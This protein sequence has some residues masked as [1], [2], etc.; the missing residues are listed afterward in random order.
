MTSEDEARQQGLPYRSRANNPPREQSYNI[1]SPN[2]MVVDT[3]DYVGAPNAPEKEHVAIINPDGGVEHEAD[4]LQDLP[5]A[6]DCA[7][8]PSRRETIHRPSIDHANSTTPSIL[9][10][11]IW[12]G[13]CR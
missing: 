3:D 2:D 13:Q 12:K 5:L 7:Y 6:N 8:P 9:F 1:P 11:H 4:Q 10:P